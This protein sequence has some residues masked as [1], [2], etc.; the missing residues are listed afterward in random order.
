MKEIVTAC[1][2][3]SL[4]Q[5]Q[6]SHYSEPGTRS[7]VTDPNGTATLDLFT[8]PGSHYTN[9][10]PA[11]TAQTLSHSE[12]ATRGTHTY[13]ILNEFSIGWQELERNRAN[14]R[15]HLKPSDQVLGEDLT[16]THSEPAT[17]GTHMHTLEFGFNS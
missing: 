1:Q 5:R 13:S 15:A 12:P 6:N 10:E 3:V 11:T 9:S 16:H 2:I 7:T 17:R 14:Y 4:L 8:E